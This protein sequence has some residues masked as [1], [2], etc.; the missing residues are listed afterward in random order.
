MMLMMLAPLA[1]IISIIGAPFT[2]FKVSGCSHFDICI[3]MLAFGW[4]QEGVKLKRAASG[5]NPWFWAQS[6]GFGTDVVIFGCFR[7]GFHQK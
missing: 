5:T 6:H 3:F 7:R 2:N 4:H 1:S